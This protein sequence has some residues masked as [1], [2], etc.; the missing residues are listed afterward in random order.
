MF[1]GNDYT[2][3]E[4]QFGS[5]FPERHWMLL[6]LCDTDQI[7]VE[8]CGS[9]PTACQR[10]SQVW[11]SQG[12]IDKKDYKYLRLN[13]GFCRTSVKLIGGAI[14][15][16]KEKTYELCHSDDVD[17][18]SMK[19]L[20]SY[21]NCMLFVIR[22][23]KLCQMEIPQWKTIVDLFDAWEGSNR[24]SKHWAHFKQYAKVEWQ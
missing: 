3:T 8:L 13:P 21:T 17:W 24:W 19:D 5:E 6:H 15:K 20:S 9:K 16:E 7:G 23:C 14:N 12:E 18:T 11:Q 2:L 1:N 22:L 10:L 4:P